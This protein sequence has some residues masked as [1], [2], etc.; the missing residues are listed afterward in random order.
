VFKRCNFHCWDA[1]TEFIP[2]T[3]DEDECGL[4]VDAPWP[5]DGDGYRHGLTTFQHRTLA[6][7][8]SLFKKTRVVVRFGDHPLIRELYPEPLW[9][10]HLQTSRTAGNNAKAEVLITRNLP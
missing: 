1:M 6:Y 9:K 4:Y 7:D 2:K 5:D 10:W 8:L 3:K